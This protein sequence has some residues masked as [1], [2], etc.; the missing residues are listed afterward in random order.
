[1]APVERPIT[2]VVMISVSRRPM[3]SPRWP[4][5]IAAER[6]RD[7]AD[8]ERRERD[9]RARARGRIEEQVAE[10]QRGG[11]AVDEE[12]VPLE[13]G[14]DGRSGDHPAELRS[15]RSAGRAVARPSRVNR[16]MLVL[17]PSEP[18]QLRPRRGRDA[19]SRARARCARVRSF[20]LAGDEDA[21]EAAASVVAAS[22]ARTLRLVVEVVGE[23]GR[24]ERDQHQAVRRPRPCSP[25]T[26]VPPS[27][28]PTS[29]DHHAQPGALVGAER[30]QRAA[31]VE[32]V[33]VVAT[34]RRCA[35]TSTPSGTASPRA[36]ATATL[37]S[38]IVAVDQ[39]MTSG[40][41]ARARP[42]ERVGAEPRARCRRTGPPSAPRC[43]TRAR[44][45]P[46]R[47]ALRP[48]RRAG[49]RGWRRGRPPSPSPYSRATRRELGD[50]QPRRDL[51]EA[52]AAVDDDVAP[53]RAVDLRLGRGVQPA[54]A[55]EAARSGARRRTPCES[56]P[57]RFASTSDSATVAALAGEAPGVVEDVAG[58]LQQAPRRCRCFPCDG[59]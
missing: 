37:P 44:P 34:A 59:T 5:S 17:L 40:G 45:G 29:L 4:N 26:P 22:A 28:P 32:G 48:T 10:H 21:V 36:R 52:A 30:Q 58:Q 38:G 31:V 54:L 50:R 6:P 57:R 2:S 3:R 15:C 1:M 47:R 43:R 25:T 8:A 16:L 19:R 7:E 39:S 11:R 23:R 49:R 9:Q 51:A 12:V 53:R 18:V 42:G 20:D 56:W 27:A 33:R 46:R 13:R 14:A 55:D 41:S 24:V 35:S